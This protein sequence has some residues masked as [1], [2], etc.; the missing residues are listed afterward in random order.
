MRK[1]ISGFGPVLV[2]IAALGCSGTSGGAEDM[3]GSVDSADA[4]ER[5]PQ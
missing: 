3:K 1:V 5:D 2:A 4:V